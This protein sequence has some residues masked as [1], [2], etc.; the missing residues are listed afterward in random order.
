M[1]LA[2]GGHERLLGDILGCLFRMTPRAQH[3]EIA[4]PVLAAIDERYGVIAV[5]AFASENLT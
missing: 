5:P 1:L 3:P 4:L 2:L